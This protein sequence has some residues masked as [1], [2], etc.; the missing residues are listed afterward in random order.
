VILRAGGLDA[1]LP[2][3]GFFVFPRSAI[4]DD[5]TF[6][7][8]LAERGV[9]CVPGTAFGVPGYFRASLTQPLAR[10]EAAAVRITRCAQSLRRAHR[11]AS[12]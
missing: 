1:T 5:R 7:R 8:L 4:A 11:V 2:D 6:C 3:G 10:I 9:L 12:A